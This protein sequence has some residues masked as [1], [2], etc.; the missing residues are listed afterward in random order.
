[1]DKNPNNIKLKKRK[2]DLKKTTFDIIIVYGHKSNNVIYTV[3]S[4]QPYLEL[5]EGSSKSNRDEHTSPLTL[6]IIIYNNSIIVIL[7]IIILLLLTLACQR[8]MRMHYICS[9]FNICFIHLQ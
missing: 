8:Y 3:I 2:S 7:T 4:K 1:M 6:I 9:F 5:N